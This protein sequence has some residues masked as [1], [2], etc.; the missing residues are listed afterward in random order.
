MFVVEKEKYAKLGDNS[1]L[2]WKKIICVHSLSGVEN[3]ESVRECGM[4][5]EILVQAQ[6]AKFLA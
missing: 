3:D 1:K 2:T 6:T 5:G 4:D